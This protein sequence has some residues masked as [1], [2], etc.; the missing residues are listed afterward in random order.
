MS[1]VSLATPTVRPIQEKSVEDFVSVAE[2]AKRFNVTTRTV[3]RWIA[4]GELPGAFQ[5]NP[6]VRNSPFLVPL[7]SVEALEKR[8]QGAEARN[9]SS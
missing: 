1:T 5:V 2:V 9:G 3:V 6:N 7:A 4:D 8:K